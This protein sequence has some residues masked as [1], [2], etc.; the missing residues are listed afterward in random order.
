MI[1]GNRIVP[2]QVRVQHGFSLVELMVTVAIIGILASIV[3]P[4]F[5]N[6]MAKAKQ[7]EAKNN[8]SLLHGLQISYHGENDIYYP[9]GNW[10]LDLAPLGFRTNSKNRYYYECVSSASDWYYCAASVRSG[11]IKAGCAFEQWI[12]SFNDKSIWPSVPDCTLQ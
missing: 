2:P 5:Q 11:K 7:A 1:P 10:T 3:V 9:N 6:F 12:V 8:L 4:Q